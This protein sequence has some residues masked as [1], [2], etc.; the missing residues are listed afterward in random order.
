MEHDELYS[1][2]RELAG[3]NTQFTTGS[4]LFGRR[5]IFK[6]SRDRERN[7]PGAWGVGNVSVEPL[8]TAIFRSVFLPAGIEFRIWRG[9]SA[10][11]W[12]RSDRAAATAARTW[13]KRAVAIYRGRAAV[14]QLVCDASV[15]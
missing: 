1:G 3:F 7:F 5:I 15:L 10:R 2:E 9:D 13:A 4:E 8:E 6:Q 14:Q 12:R 11:L